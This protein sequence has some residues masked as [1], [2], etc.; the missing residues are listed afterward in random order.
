MAN[1][2]RLRPCAAGGQ[3]IT[4]NAIAPGYVPSKMSAQLGAYEET[5][6]LAEGGVPLRRMGNAGGVTHG[7]Y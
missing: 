2:D 3:S 1:I 6:G 4:V 7:G 5:K